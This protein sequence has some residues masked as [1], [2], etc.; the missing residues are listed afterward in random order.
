MRLFEHGAEL[1]EQRARGLYEKEAFLR[2]FHRALPP[3]KAAHAR[4]D[5]DARRQPSIDEQACQPFGFRLSA[6]S[7]QNH[8]QVCHAVKKNEK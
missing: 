6:A 1:L 4:D 3:V 2:R 8:N 5:A 7:I